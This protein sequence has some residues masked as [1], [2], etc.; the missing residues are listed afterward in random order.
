[1]NLPTIFGIIFGILF[2]AGGYWYWQ[3]MPIVNTSDE[4]EITDV[5]TE[6]P[7]ELSDEVPSDPAPSSPPPPQSSYDIVMKKIVG[8]WRNIESEG[9]IYNIKDG[10]VFQE[11]RVVGSGQ[12]MVPQGT[13]R[14]E[15]VGTV[16]TFDTTHPPIGTLLFVRTSEKGDERWYEL[17]EVT[18][19]T[20]A[21]YEIAGG[22]VYHFTRME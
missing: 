9:L 6:V 13:W 20:L 15:K 4:N 10:A 3:G 2:L 22:N 8:K 21:L 12:F 11:S 18:E 16:T 17:R 14:L 7:E 1:M 5:S 19:T